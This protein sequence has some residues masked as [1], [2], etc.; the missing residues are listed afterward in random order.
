[1]IHRLYVPQYRLAALFWSVHMPVLTQLRPLTTHSQLRPLSSTF[2]AASLEQYIRSCVPWTAHLQLR[3]LT[4]H[5]QLRPLNNKF[6]ATSLEQHIRSCVRWA[7]HLQLRPLTTHSQLRPL[8]STF[9]VFN[10]LQ[11]A[12][13]GSIASTISYRG[14]QYAYL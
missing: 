3:P 4:A 7:A 12:A 9:A 2:A 8:S 13:A 5:S 1:M 14:R 11:S 6:A 10:H